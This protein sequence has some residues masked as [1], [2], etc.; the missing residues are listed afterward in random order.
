MSAYRRTLEELYGLA[1]RGIQPGLERMRR[2]LDA[3]DHPEDGLEVAHVA[4]TN[5]KGSVARMIAA[6][7]GGGLF[8]SPHLHSLTERFQIDGEPVREDDVA[9]TWAAIRGS[10]A[11][12]P[13]TFFETV[14]LLAFA[15]FRRAGV[16]RVTLE[17]GLGGRLDSTN[18][19]ARPAVTAITRVGLDHTAILGEDLGAIAAEKA[20]VLKPGVP[21]VLAPQAPEAEAAIVRVARRVGA[22]LLRPRLVEPFGVRL[23]DRAYDGP[24]PRLAG[25]HQRQNAAVAAG[26]LIALGADDVAIGR[27]LDVTWPGRLETIDGVLLDGAHNPDGA[28]ALAAHLAGGPKVSL[29]IGINRGK[30][31]AA[32]LAALRPVAARV[33]LTRAKLDRAMPPEELAAPGDRVLADVADALAYARSFDAP[34]VVAGSLFVVAEARAA[35]LGIAG[36]PPIAM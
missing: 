17:V 18:V 20:G 14:T 3:L 2:A 33:V 11:G 22:R 30:D 10:I 24:P 6:G 36:D 27:G 34:V 28:A 1:P 16:R 23:D 21:C 35:L 12:V 31:H 9:D 4:G 32:M 8:T 19:I 13:L 25:A 5:G 29:V 15:L 7:W 26:A